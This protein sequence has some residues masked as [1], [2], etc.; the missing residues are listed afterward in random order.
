VAGALRWSPGYPPAF[1]PHTS[2][3]GGR[4]PGLLHIAFRQGANRIKDYVLTDAPGEWF[5]KWAVNR[6]AAEGAGAKWIAQNAD[7]FLLVADRE[8]LAGPNMG[9]ARG[10]LQLLARR[11]AAEREDRPVALVWSKADVAVAAEMESA[12]RRTVTEQMP[13]AIEFSVSVKSASQ[14]SGSGSGLLELLDW[15]LSGRRARTRLADH[16]RSSVDPP[17]LFGAR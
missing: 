14:D 12:V 17:F 2:S 3:R 10:G 1:P 16:D 4:A 13:D 15:T 6:D 5:T 11:L 7:V 9:S 8:A